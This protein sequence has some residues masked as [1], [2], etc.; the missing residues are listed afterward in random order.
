MTGAW[1]MH[2]FDVLVLKQ[3]FGSRVWNGEN[4]IWNTIYCIPY[5]HTLSTDSPHSS[6]LDLQG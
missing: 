6:P 3:I 5:E 2:N 4:H 1:D